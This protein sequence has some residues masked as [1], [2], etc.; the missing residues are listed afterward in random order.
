L[1]KAALSNSNVILV[2]KMKNPNDVRLARR[3]SSNLK[4]YIRFRGFQEG[5][6]VMDLDKSESELVQVHINGGL[7]YSIPLRIKDDLSTVGC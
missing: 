1:D 2:L 5:I 6:V 4:N 3:R 7:L